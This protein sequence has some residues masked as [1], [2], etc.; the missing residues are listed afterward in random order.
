MRNK[1]TNIIIIILLIGLSSY[2]NAQT[3]NPVNNT[4][5]QNNNSQAASAVVQL[6][7]H[8]KK[9]T[10]ERL[11]IRNEYK[12]SKLEVDLRNKILGEFKGCY[13]LYTGKTTLTEQEE[14]QFQLE[15]YNYKN[16]K[17]NRYILNEPE[18]RELK[19]QQEFCYSAITQPFQLSCIEQVYDPYKLNAKKFNDFKGILIETE[20]YEMSKDQT[21]PTNPNHLKGEIE[22]F[23]LKSIN[24]C[25]L[26]SQLKNKDIRMIFDTKTIKMNNIG[27]KIKYIDPIYKD[28]EMYEA[29]IEYIP[30]TKKENKTFKVHMVTIKEQDL[31]FKE[32]MQELWLSI[33]LG[34]AM[35]GFAYLF[36]KNKGEL[37]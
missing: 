21:K 1:K 25:Y 3:N 4:T 16:P 9:Q 33:L 36:I 30:I 5:A 11:G 34:I 8:I 13:E 35:I 22:V 27:E 7:E 14:N 2:V 23:S 28:T 19:Q 12:D 31:S 10:I 6:S 32:K 17:M 29:N 20:E 15:P 24:A 18:K 37:P 26:N